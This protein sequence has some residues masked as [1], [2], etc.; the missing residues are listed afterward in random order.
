MPNANIVNPHFAVPFR[1]R[2]GSA[3]C[4]EQDSPEDV[5]QCVSAIVRTQKG[6]RLEIPGFGIDN[7]VMQEN[8]PSIP[9]LEAAL[10]TWEPRADFTLEKKELEDV[11]SQLLKIKV[12]VRAGG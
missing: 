9:E 11:L 5:I 10:R 2:E 4:V 12:G 3:L 6:F 7:P 1:I 8:G